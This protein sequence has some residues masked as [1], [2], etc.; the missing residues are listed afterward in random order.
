MRHGI[1]MAAAT[2]VSVL[3][4]AAC[5]TDATPGRSETNDSSASA[6]ETASASPSGGS[7]AP[8]EQLDATGRLR[9]TVAT[10]DKDLVAAGGVKFTVGGSSEKD[11]DAVGLAPDGSQTR[12]WKTEEG[13]PAAVITV[14]G[15]GV[16][17]TKSSLDE[18]GVDLMTS[19]APN[20][21]WMEE[22]FQPGTYVPL[23]PSRVVE[24]ILAYAIETVCVAEE[25]GWTCRIQSAGMS[26]VPG[27]GGFES[28]DGIL[29]AEVALDADGSLVSVEI[30]PSDN[31]LNLTFGDIEFIAVDVRRP[32]GETVMYETLI[33]EQEKRQATPSPEATLE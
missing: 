20:A 26:T 19:V 30:F 15:E 4:L 16:F 31:V 18:I 33:A 6:T 2:A 7:V 17:S 22:T 24:S 29:E 1:V 12:E 32:D 3:C 25:S 21:E 9:D 27:L 14:V 10:F 28:P 13:N 23:S 5:T 8:Q 11:P